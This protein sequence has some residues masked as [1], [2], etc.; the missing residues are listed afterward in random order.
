M[1][2]HAIVLGGGIAGMQ[3][4]KA[5]A[6]RYSRV[7]LIERDR[8]AH[9]G[10]VRKT[11]PQGAHAHGLLARGLQLI[12]GAFPGI[13]DEIVAGGATLVGP[14]DVRIYIGGWRKAHGSPLRILSTTRPYLEWA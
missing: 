10:S 5:L 3:A 4:A 6:A 2:G 8:L 12:E 11:V 7:T 13:V 1:S 14:H 9:D